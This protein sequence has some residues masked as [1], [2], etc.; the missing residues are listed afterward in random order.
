MW[1]DLYRRNEYYCILNNASCEADA[2]TKHLA[3]LIRHFKHLDKKYVGYIY[4]YKYKANIISIAEND[5]NVLKFKCILKA[6][7]FGWDINISEW[8]KAV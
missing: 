1:E 4:S 8:S 3:I 5:L 6:I 7:E 2:K